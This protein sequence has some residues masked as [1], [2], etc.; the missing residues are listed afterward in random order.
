ME[1]QILDSQERAFWN[2]HRPPVRSHCYRYFST[3]ISGMLLDAGCR[4]ISLA[5]VAKKELNSG[6]DF[7]QKTRT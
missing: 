7:M 2:V 5:E 1:R 3:V 4:L 6:F